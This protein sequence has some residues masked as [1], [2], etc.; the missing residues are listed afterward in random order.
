M[1]P[2]GV[3]S[4]LLAINKNEFIEYFDP[5]RMVH[6]VDF[7]SLEKFVS[8]NNVRRLIEKVL[9]TRRKYFSSLTGSRQGSAGAMN[10]PG[11]ISNR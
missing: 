6:S 7:P 1:P 11:K 10:S 3:L 2:G 9:K 8:P 5:T 4:V